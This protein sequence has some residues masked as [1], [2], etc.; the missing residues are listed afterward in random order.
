MGRS[1]RHY[2]MVA[3]RQESADFLQRRRKIPKLGCPRLPATRISVI[4]AAA[5]ENSETWLSQIAVPDCRICRRVERM[6]GN[7]DTHELQAPVPKLL[8]R[9]ILFTASAN[10]SMVHRKMLIEA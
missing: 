7:Q 4:L 5:S 6:Q 1:W 3:V 2:F 10:G 9:A 8:A